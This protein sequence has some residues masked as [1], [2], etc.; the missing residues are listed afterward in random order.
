MTKNNKF[1]DSDVLT[2]EE[3]DEEI[4]RLDKA[5]SVKSEVEKIKEK[6]LAAKEEKEKEKNQSGDNAADDGTNEKSY[7]DI[8]SFF[9]IDGVD[10]NYSGMEIASSYPEEVQNNDWQGVTRATGNNKL[11]IFKFDIT[12]NTGAEY[13]LDMSKYKC[14]YSL[15]LNDSISKTPITTMLLNDFIY[16]KGVIQPG[17]KITNVIIIQASEED[18]TGIEYTVMKMKMGDKVSEVL[19]K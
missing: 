14:K 19:L 2:D 10:I 3:L 6:K 1:Y 5:S 8:K 17:E 11:V 4:E 13:E 9:E 12:N 16:Y 7:G 18:T 15:K